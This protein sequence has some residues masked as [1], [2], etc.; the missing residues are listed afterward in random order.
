MTRIARRG[1]GLDSL[2]SGLALAAL[3]PATAAFAH[4]VLDEARARFDEAEF[5]AAL[6]LLASAEQRS[7]L[8]ASDLEGL[9]EL[10]AIAAVANGDPA[11]MRRAL[12]SLASIAPEHSLGNDAPPEVIEVFERAR[13]RTSARL[14]IAVSAERRGEHVQIRASA[15]ND[16]TSL[17]RELRLF[18]RVNGAAWQPAADAAIAVNAGPAAAIEYYAEAVGPGGATLAAD[19]TAA[20]PQRISAPDLSNAGRARGGGGGGGGGIS[21]WIW[22]AIG[23]VAIGAGVTIAVV[24]TRPQSDITRPLLPTIV[25]D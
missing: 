24:A 5:A 9:L 12:A 4:P 13:G 21:P 20:R 10:R 17:V 19:G 7:D 1:L 11:T 23:A 14:R 18:V 16:P 3:L 22:V 8:T 15:D 2:V 25:L 6:E